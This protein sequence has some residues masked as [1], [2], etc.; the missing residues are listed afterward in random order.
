M[1]EI[2]FETSLSDTDAISDLLIGLGALSVTVE[3]AQA[4]RPD[5]SPLFGEPG[6]PT[7]VQAWPTSKFMVLLDI[8]TAPAQF[9]AEFCGQDSRFADW[10]YEI[11]EIG[12]RDWVAE[13]Q[14]QFTPFALR[15]ELWV[16]PHWTDP[17]A[18]FVDHGIVIRLDPGMA[19]GTGSH[20]TTQLCLEQLVHAIRATRSTSVRLLDMGCGSGILAIAAA[21][22]GAAEVHAVDIDPIAVKTARDNASENQVTITLHDAEDALHGPFDVVVANILSQ[23]LKLLA[24]MLTRYTRPGGCLLL[25]GILSRQ[26]EEILL[27]YH[28]LTQHIPS[29]RVLDERDGWVCIGNIPSR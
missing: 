25:S 8:Q 20:A 14:R 6:M 15:D 13:T 29:L 9:W 23:P 1:H 10:P 21:K 18:Q 2:V 7:A 22:L 5:E 17:P 26:A 28:P 27:A 12:E 11:R 24:P 16:G 3:D 4:N 19:F